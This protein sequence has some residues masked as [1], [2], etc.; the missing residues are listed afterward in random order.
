MIREGNPPMHSRILLIAAVFAASL[1]ISTA[2]SALS[3]TV[4]GSTCGSCQGTDI[5]L[6][7]IDNIGSFDVTLTIN[8][9][10]YTGKK[11]GLVQVGFGGI[12]GWSSVALDSS[13]ASSAVAWSNPI[14]ANVSSSGLCKNGSNTDKIC[15]TGFVD[16]SGGGDFVWEFTVNGGTLRPDTYDWHIGGQF[17]DLSDLTSRKGPKGNLISE[18]GSKPVPEPRS[19]MLFAL[20]AL[21]CARTITHKR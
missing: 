8:A 4:G 15:S 14:A 21:V 2:A 1:A 12:S 20:G 9:D 6:E 5:E 13:P 10:N 19:A 11:D 17:A 7:I 3:L 16:I 18:P